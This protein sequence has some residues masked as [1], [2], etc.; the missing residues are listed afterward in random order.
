V[1]QKIWP[2]AMAWGELAGSEIM[3]GS[4]QTSQRLA[5]WTTSIANTKTEELKPETAVGADLTT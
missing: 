5:G 2:H 3:Y 1:R 4:R